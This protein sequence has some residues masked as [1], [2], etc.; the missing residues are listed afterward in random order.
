MSGWMK[1]KLVPVTLSRPDP[2]GPI[3]GDQ[4]HARQVGRVGGRELQDVGEQQRRRDHSHHHRG[5]LLEADGEGGGGRKAVI[6]AVDQAGGPTS[7]VFH[8]AT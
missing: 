1:A 5:D 6:E 8:Q 3:R 4:R 7:L 2:I